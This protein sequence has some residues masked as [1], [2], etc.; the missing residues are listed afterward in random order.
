M[1]LRL[2]RRVKGA[3]L[4]IDCS[5][6]VCV[7]CKRRETNRKYYATHRASDR[8]SRSAAK[9]NKIYDLKI[10]DHSY[11]ET[12]ERSAPSSLALFVEHIVG[13]GQSRRLPCA[14]GCE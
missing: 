9:W 14:R 3:N 7:V 6:G 13:R 4:V 11:Y 8:S 12:P 1:V 5:C 2:P 10:A